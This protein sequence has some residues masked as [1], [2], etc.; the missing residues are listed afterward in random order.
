MLSDYFAHHTLYW[1]K[2]RNDSKLHRVL[3]MPVDQLFQAVHT[4]SKP[5]FVLSTGRT[6]TKLLTTILSHDPGLMIAHKPHPE[7]THYANMAY[8]QDGDGRNLEYMIDACRY[9]SIRDCYLLEKRYV[10]T[11]NRITYFCHQLAELYPRSKF[12]HLE[13]DV[14]AFV[15]SGFSRNWYTYQKLFDEGRITP[16]PGSKWDWESLSQVEKITWLWLETNAFIKE[17]AKKL[18]PARS[19]YLSSE[20]LYSSAEDV[21]SLLDFLDIE[22]IDIATIRKSLKRPVNAQPSRK[23]KHLSDEQRDQ[24][25]SFVEQYNKH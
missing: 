23:R 5:V 15:A 21:K 4:E 2:L 24:I 13:R 12:V 3:P 25:R 14:Y 10:E 9:E 18:D 6:G 17:F 1:T 8:Q 16:K 7:L 20:S 11:N 22:S 19:F